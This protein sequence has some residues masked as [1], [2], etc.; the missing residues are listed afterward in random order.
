MDFVSGLLLFS[1]VSGVDF[2]PTMFGAPFDSNYMF[3]SP[4]YNGHLQSKYSLLINNNKCYFNN[5]DFMQGFSTGS[6]WANLDHHNYWSDLRD[7]SDGS[8]D[9]V[10]IT[11]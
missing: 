1:L 3:N 8:N 11:F 10:A 4:R 9:G 6:L 2:Q 5:P 7:Y